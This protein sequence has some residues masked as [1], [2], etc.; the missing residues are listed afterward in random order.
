VDDDGSMS[1]LPV[2]QV[3]RQELIKPDTPGVI[4]VALRTD[5]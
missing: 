5:T 1:A 2:A 4:A 3:S